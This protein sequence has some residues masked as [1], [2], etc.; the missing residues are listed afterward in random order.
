MAIFQKSKE[1]G[2]VKKMFKWVMFDFGRMSG[3]AGK[4]N[5][6]VTNMG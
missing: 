5:E 1:I 2:I 3:V 4:Q 6:W